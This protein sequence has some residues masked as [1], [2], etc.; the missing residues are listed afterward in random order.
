MMSKM[1]DEKNFEKF[2][3]GHPTING[4]DTIYKGRRTRKK[5][6]VVKEPPSYDLRGTQHV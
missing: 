2:M 6:K 4:N 1:L 5:T 3:Y